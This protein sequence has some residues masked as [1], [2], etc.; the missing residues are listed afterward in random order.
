M[1]GHT[2]NEIVI[3][4][5]MDLVWDRTNDVESWPELF[6]EYASAEITERLEGG[7]V[8]FRLTMHPDE[9]GN[10]WSWVSERTPDP[11]ARTVKAHRVETGFF[12]YM[13]LYWEYVEVG[14]GVKLRWVQDFH[15][16]SEAPIDDD[17]MTDRINFNSKI[18]LAHIKGR[19][20]EAA[21]HVGKG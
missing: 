2:D 18:Q 8:R 1:A 6:T 14:G 4:A 7:A 5:P 19:L 16:K 13:N 17:A 11:A 15:M 10:A 9:N 3:S 20:E 21:K 12:E